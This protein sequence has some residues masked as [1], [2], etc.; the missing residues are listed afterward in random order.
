VL[1]PYPDNGWEEFRPRI[2]TAL[3][4]YQKIASPEGIQRI[5]VRYINRI[6]IPEKNVKPGMYFRCAPRAI[7]VLP[8]AMEAFLQRSEYVYADGIKLVTTFATI[9]GPSDRSNFL[10]D[11]DVIWDAAVPLSV[12]RP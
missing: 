3:G 4:C 7:E 5:G 6:E 2:E 1:R 10:L 9:E 12:S 11:L 8:P